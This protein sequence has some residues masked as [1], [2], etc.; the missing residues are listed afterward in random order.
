[1]PALIHKGKTAYQHKN[2]SQSHEIRIEDI[3]RVVDIEATIRTNSGGLQVHYTEEEKRLDDQGAV[4]RIWKPKR[5]WMLEPWSAEDVELS[6][7]M[8][9]QSAENG[10]C[11]LTEQK[12]G[13]TK[14][15][16]NLH[17]LHQDSMQGCKHGHLMAQPV[18]VG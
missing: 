12:Q 8:V 6:S 13:H 7:N 1:M 4:G 2:Q 18:R 14:G 11:P 17:V 15:I 5:G 3:K 10:Y 16:Y 9:P